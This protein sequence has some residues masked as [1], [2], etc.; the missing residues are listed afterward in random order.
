[1]DDPMQTAAARHGRRRES[2]SCLAGEDDSTAQLDMFA[3]ADE[4]R[5]LRD[6]GMSAALHAS[7]SH[8]KAAA[9]DALADLIASGLEFTA[10][11][12]RARVGVLASSPNALGALIAKAARRDQI[13]P[14]GVTTS[15]RPERHGGLLRTWKGVRDAG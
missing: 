6:D 12:L 2:T 8:W 3:A 14:T 1:M 7:D 5:R 9:E 15:T 10:D 4:G 13:A 11:D